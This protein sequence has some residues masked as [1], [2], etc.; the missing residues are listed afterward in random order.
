MNLVLSVDG[1]TGRQ[2]LSV[3]DDAPLEDLL[4]AIVRECGGSE[5][6]DTFDAIGWRLAPQGEAP[7]QPGQ[8]LS[9]V[10]VFPGAVL[11]LTAPEPVVEAPPAPRPPRVDSMG[12]RD[13]IRTLDAAISARRAPSSHVIAVV[14]GQPGAGATT[15]TALL[16]LASSALLDE[17]VVAVDANPGSG[18]LSH[19][20][21]PD[22]ALPG[23]LYRSLFASDATPGIVS[24]ALMRAGPRLA[25]VPAPVDPASVQSGDGAGWSRLI[26]H[27]RR[28]HHVVV[29]D[30]GTQ[31]AVGWAD[32]V[33]LVKRFN[34]GASSSIQG[35]QPLVTVINQARR[36]RRIHGKDVTIAAEPR[37]A[38]RLKRRGF[39]WADAPPAWQEGVRELAA[40]LLAGA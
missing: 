16:A 9:E 18:A 29:V 15:V 5:W 36:R 27:L 17:S 10:G 14:G 30:C 22:R 31:R 8:R 20:L 21:V 12:E 34:Q 4:P 13:Y 25:V 33:V 7:M 6:R 26:E 19:W 32:A 39:A 35:S 28:M 1:P 38:A 37:A 11:V 2:L 23:D 3:P 40:V 24:R